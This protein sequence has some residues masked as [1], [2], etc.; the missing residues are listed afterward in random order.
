MW[1]ISNSV[2]VHVEQCAVHSIH[3]VFRQTPIV[4]LIVRYRDLCF[5]LS[6]QWNF[7][8]GSLSLTDLIPVPII[9]KWDDLKWVDVL[10]VHTNRCLLWPGYLW[11]SFGFAGLDFFWHQIQIF[12]TTV[13]SCL[14]QTNYIQYIFYCLLSVREA[15]TC[16]W[17]CITVL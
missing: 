14:I 6:D 3:V 8:W 13:K 5:H 4:T 16:R 2:S 7:S 11:R 9:S 15:L 10:W 17:Q 12:Q 1:H